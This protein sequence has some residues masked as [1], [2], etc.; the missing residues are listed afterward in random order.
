MKKI[1]KRMAVLL[2]TFAMIVSAI[3]PVSAFAD[4]EAP[5][6]EPTVAGLAIPFGV[7]EPNSFTYEGGSGRVTLSCARVHVTNVFRAEISFSS[8]TYPYAEVDGVRY[9]AFVDENAKTTTFTIPVK[10]GKPVV[11]SAYSTKMETLIPY[12]VTVDLDKTNLKPVSYKALQD[13]F[14]TTTVSSN[15]ETYGYVINTNGSIDYGFSN[16]SADYDIPVTIEVKDGKVC[17]VAYTNDINDIMS[18]EAMINTGSDVNYLLWAMEGA[19]VTDATYDYMKKSKTSQYNKYHLDPWPA[20]NGR[21]LKEQIIEKNGIVGVDAVTKASITSRAVLDSVDQSLVKAER[22][23][24]DDPVPD[25]PKPDT[26]DDIIP[27]EEGLYSVKAKCIGADLGNDGEMLI[28]VKDGKMTAKLMYIEQRQSSYPHIYPGIWEEAVADEDGWLLPTDYDYDYYTSSGTYA[29]GSLY[30][31]VPLK[32]LDKQLRFVMYAKSSSAWFNRLLKLDSTTL[33]KLSD[34]EA[35]LKYA[36]ADMFIAQAEMKTADQALDKLLKNESATAEQLKAAADAYAKA[37]KAA[38]EKA[39]EA[40]AKSNAVQEEEKQAMIAA[41][42]EA[43]KKIAELEVQV[44]QVKSVKAKAGK[45]KATV[46]WKKLGSGY[47]Y[48]VYVSTKV[49]SGFKKK[50]T[51]SKLKVDVKKLKSKKTYYVKVRGV[52]KVNGKTVRTAFSDLAKVKVK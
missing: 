9:D 52:K 46:S 26:S 39:A 40:T 35:E 1:M 23:Q 50:A 49:N 3:G 4:D 33:K 29:P 5:V 37:A 42:E 2:V 22:G 30:K 10:L 6:P 19:C 21:G 18:E 41:A 45:K 28:E 12:T 7:Y 25:L 51:T 20:K 48:E 14:Y 17:D 32:S 13:G 44:K 11:I 16:P 43:A 47:K 31:D 24:K 34:K 15:R 38:T 8:T 36:E 27:T